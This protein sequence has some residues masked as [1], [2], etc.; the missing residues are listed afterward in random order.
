MMQSGGSSGSPLNSDVSDPVPPNFEKLDIRRA[1][2]EPVVPFTAASLKYSPA[3]KRDIP[4]LMSMR[5][6]SL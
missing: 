5:S 2:I 3:P 6:F 4:E 1:W